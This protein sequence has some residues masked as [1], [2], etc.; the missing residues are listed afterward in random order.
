MRRCPTSE[1]L[2]ADC[3]NLGEVAG[4]LE[5]LRWFNRWFG[6]ISTVRNLLKEVAGR[7][8]Q[9][10]FSVLEVAAAEGYIPQ[11]LTLELRTAGI[12]LEITLLDRLASHLP[13]N[14]NFAKIVADALHL[15]FPESSFDV[16]CCSLF[17]HHL[18]PDEVVQF[19]GEA[20]RVCRVALL[21]HDLIRHPL[22][23]ALAYAGIPFYQSRL[24]RNDAPASVH[25][26]YTVPEM[27]DLLYRAGSGDVHIEEHFLFRMGA[28]AWK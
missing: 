8:R 26:A 3:G 24:T 21:A 5:D 27:R 11:L 22:H 9:R 15:P 13:S 23:L 6:G 1:L 10:E 19:A 25:Q 17:L 4:S 28:A 18:C 16:V 20:L 7:T 14:G 2:D 12:R